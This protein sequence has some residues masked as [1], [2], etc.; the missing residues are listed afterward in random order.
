MIFFR[1]STALA[2]FNAFDYKGQGMIHREDIKAVTDFVFGEE[3]E[4]IAAKGEIGSLLNHERLTNI[5]RKNFN[6]YFN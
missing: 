5:E 4:L 6:N 3:D 1:F 2:A